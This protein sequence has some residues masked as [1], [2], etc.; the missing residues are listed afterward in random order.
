VIDLGFVQL[1][2]FY[3]FNVLA[4]VV[5]GSLAVGRLGR[6]RFPWHWALEG[7]SVAILGGILGTV[8]AWQLLRIVE[9]LFTGSSTSFGAGGSTVFGGILFGAAAGLGYC[10]WRGVPIGRAFDRGI[11]AL[12]LGQGIG[13]LGCFFAGCCFG[14][15]AD[16]WLGMHLPG[17]VGVWADRFPTQLLSSLA[18]FGIFGVLMVIDRRLGGV[19]AAYSRG[20]FPGFLTLLYMFLYFSKRFAMEFIRAERPLVWGPFTWAHVASAIGLAVAAGL[21]VFHR[22]RS[23]QKELL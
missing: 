5:A 12:P 23:A 15:A 11:P 1:H 22:K 2:T 4:V 18:D 10:R 16:S 21:W 7:M 20:W 17:E 19:P 8:V 14:R 3:V 13:R 6:S 9:W